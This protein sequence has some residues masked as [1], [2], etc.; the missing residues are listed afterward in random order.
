MVTQNNFPLAVLG[1]GSEAV[2][3]TTVSVFRAARKCCW[4]LVTNQPS[5]GKPARDRIYPPPLPGSVS[6]SPCSRYYYFCF[7]FDFVCFFI[8]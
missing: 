2:P 6:L 3:H 8:L 4:D 7:S 1:P 5:S